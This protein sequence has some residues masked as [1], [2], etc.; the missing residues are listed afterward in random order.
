[1]AQFKKQLHKGKKKV[2]RKNQEVGYGKKKMVALY[3][4]FFGLL[5]AA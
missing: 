4:E 2:E 1:V 5:S 3:H